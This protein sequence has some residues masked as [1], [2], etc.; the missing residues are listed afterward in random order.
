MSSTK[1]S[2]V[3]RTP[4]SAVI[5]TKNEELFIERCIKSVDWADEVLVF[6]SGSTDRTREIA[7]SLGANVQEQEWLGWTEQHQKAL[8]AARNDWVFVIDCDEIVTPELHASILET[9]GKPMDERDGY[10]VDRRDEFL[11]VLLPNMR[12]R[13][14]RL[15]FVRLFNRRHSG[16]DPTMRVHEEIRFP[17]KAV[18]LEGFLLHWRAP[19]ISDRMN[20]INHYSTIEAEELNDN[21]HRATGL[22]IVSRPVLRFMWCYVACGGFRCGTR[23]LMDAILRGISE[24][25]RDVKLWEM[26]NAPKTLHPPAEV[27]KEASVTQKPVSNRTAVGQ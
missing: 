11:G 21:G 27:Y 2:A 18:Q 4:I 5:L 20:S 13:S 16:Y 12:R 22:R 14:K 1:E 17:G 9:A 24:F 23:G 26:Q 15:N 3:V 10:A 25:A 7:R 6:D 19:T 8:A